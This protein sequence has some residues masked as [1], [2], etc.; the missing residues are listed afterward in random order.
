MKSAR[1][2]KLVGACVMDI[3]LSGSITLEGTG[4]VSPYEDKELPSYRTG[5]IQN[6][7][8]EEYEHL[9]GYPVPSGKWAGE[10]ELNDAVCQMYYAKSGLA[11]LAY[12]I[13]TDK[14]VKNKKNGTPDLNLLFQYNIP[15]QAITKIGRMRG[16]A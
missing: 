13:L 9:L 2:R 10:L 5:F 8:K 7:G 15:F 4:A 12:K 11:R 16:K 1:Q 14:K 6:V 3:R